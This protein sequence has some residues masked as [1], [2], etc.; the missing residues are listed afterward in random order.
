MLGVVEVALIGGMRAFPWNS[1]KAGSL[2]IPVVGGCFDEDGSCLVQPEL[3]SGGG[4]VEVEERL[5]GSWIFT[6]RGGG[7]SRWA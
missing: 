5:S 1:S 2:M 7:R 6:L 3:N 4:G